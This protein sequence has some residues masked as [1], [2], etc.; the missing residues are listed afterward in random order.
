VALA[1]NP[2]RAV[3]ELDEDG[4][5]TPDNQK[6]LTGVSEVDGAAQGSARD[7]DTSDAVPSSANAP[8]TE[9]SVEQSDEAGDDAPG[10]NE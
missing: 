4:S 9:A 5:G 1:R 6:A 8:V 7:S 3:D 10:G 2:E